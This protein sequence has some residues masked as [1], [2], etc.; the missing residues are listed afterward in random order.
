MEKEKKEDTKFLDSYSVEADGLTAE[1]RIVERKN[2]FVREYFIDFPQ[3]GEGTEALLKELKNS[4]IAET[5]IKSDALIDQKV[6]NALKARFR[7]R[8]EKILARELPN[9]T[10]RNKNAL[11]GVLLEE[12]LGLGKLDLILA[13]AGLEEIVVNQST[14]PVWVY[15]KKFGWLKTNVFAG[16]EDDIHNYGSIIA[17]RIGKQITTLDPLLDAHLTTGDRVNATL[18][19]ISN[20]GNTLTIR[21]FRR[22]PWTV[23]DL[24][25]QGTVSSEVMA[26]L[27]Q[28]IQ[29]E[30]NVIFSGGTASGKTTGLG[31]CIP[32]IQANHRIISIEDTR[33][34]KPPE[35]MHYIPLT[36]R[37]PNPEG[38]GGISMLD[39]LVNS[40]RMR[41]DRIIVGEI[42]RK[43]EAEVMFEGMHTGHSV[44]TTIHANTAD[45]TIRRL[46]NPP[47]NIPVSML[48]AV[49]LNVVMFRNRR[50][51]VRRVLQVGE[52]VLEKHSTTEEE[53]K[54]NIL[55]RWR[56]SD[57]KIVKHNESIRL[58]DELSLHTGLN[59]QEV[60]DEIDEKQKILEW[61][62]KFNINKV[63]SV[64]KIVAQYYK[65]PESVLEAVKKGKPMEEEDEQ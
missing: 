56:G 4:L 22:D 62:C 53:V 17:R 48:D 63:N 25:N 1:V 20:N 45:E 59:K 40:L 24:I 47:I 58:F 5:S 14:E 38:K 55:Y 33:E 11:I 41:P 64:G 49:H 39:L 7:D 10:E 28:G 13:D 8:A 3:L 37:E 36:T 51:G 9:V 16:S 50:L 32:F 43:K 19:P 57:D 52:F 61:M 44:Y 2:S 21:K 60:L 18:F 26:L 29:Y 6:V 54:A 12:M 27:W 30:L 65:E 35:F 15:H 34:L 42:R 31:V 23:T 46:T